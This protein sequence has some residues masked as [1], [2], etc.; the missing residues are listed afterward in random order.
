MAI[1]IVV[2]FVVIE[3]LAKKHRD[4]VDVGAFPLGEDIL[5]SIQATTNRALI[6]A[7]VGAAD[8]V[9][10]RKTLRPTAHHAW[11]AA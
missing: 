3:E 9:S 1:K 6:P 11:S 2:F 8:A 7:I 10:V 4:H 5:Q